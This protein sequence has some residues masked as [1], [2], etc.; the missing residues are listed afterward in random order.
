[1]SPSVPRRG[2]QW[3]RDV[4]LMSAR[5]RRVFPCDVR[6]WDCRLLH[7]SEGVM[8]RIALLRDGCHAVR[9]GDVEL[10][11]RRGRSLDG[12]LVLRGRRDRVRIRD[13]GL[14]Q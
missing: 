6:L 12:E 11:Q 10:L 3:D 13:V 2:L 7:G 5:L 14:L 4:F 9:G 1:M 8:D